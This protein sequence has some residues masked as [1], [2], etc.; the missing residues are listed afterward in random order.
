MS[1]GRL[2]STDGG[3]Q[4]TVVDAKGDLLVGVAADSV[5]RLAVGNNGETLVADS[6]TS[7][8]LRW[9]GNQA[10]GRNAL[11]NGGFDIWQRGTSGFTG[12]AYNAD[13]WYLTQSGGT[14]TV[15]R[16]S[17]IVPTG[18]VY[19]LKIAQTVANGTAYIQQVI[20]TLNAIQFAGKTIVVSLDA[21][22]TAST[23]FAIGVEYSTGTD[24]A[25]TGSFTNITATS[26]GTATITSTTFV[27]F[28]GVFAI[29]S[30]AKTIK[31]FVSAAISS[32]QSAY[33]G[34]IQFELGSVATPFSRAGGTLAGELAACQR[35]YVNFNANADATD[36][37]IGIGFA[38]SSTSAA[39]LIYLPVEMRTKPSTLDWTNTAVNAIT[40]EYAV[41]ALSFTSACNNRNIAAVTATV[42]SGLTTNA[43]YFLS[44]RSSSKLGIGAEL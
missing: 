1:T 30:N 21:A 40:A 35:Y 31:V 3:I 33:L 14:A 27:N 17:T 18:A 2:P 11:I 16:E 6:S 13:R 15:S 41:T 36:P 44:A 20:E 12:N 28:S 7:T 38:S 9:Q 22:A 29:P 23:N 43:P 5:S 32:G 19:S 4:P 8:G 42:A 24:T 26:G 37:R 39:F 10:A 25:V 34:K